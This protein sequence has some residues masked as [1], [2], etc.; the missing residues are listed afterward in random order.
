MISRHMYSVCSY[1]SGFVY[2]LVIDGDGLSG[3]VRSRMNTGKGGFTF[4]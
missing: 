4:L 1:R 3:S 2:D